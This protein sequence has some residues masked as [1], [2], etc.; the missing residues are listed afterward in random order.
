MQRKIIDIVIERRNKLETTVKSDVI[1]LAYVPCITI[2]PR[3]KDQIFVPPK[4]KKTKK[5]WSFPIS[6]FKDWKKDDE[7]YYIIQFFF[8]LHNKNFHLYLFFF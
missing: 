3:T 2:P 7:V 4:R 6:I 8:S 1:G 5:V